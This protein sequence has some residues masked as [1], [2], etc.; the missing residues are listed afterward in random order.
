MYKSEL[1]T[2][3]TLCTSGRPLP[4][5]AHIHTGVRSSTCRRLR[6]LASVIYFTCSMLANSG[7][8]NPSPQIQFTY[9]HLVDIR[10]NKSLQL[11]ISTSSCG[12][13]VAAS[14]NMHKQGGPNL[15]SCFIS[16]CTGKVGQAFHTSKSC[17]TFCIPTAV[18]TCLSFSFCT[19][20]AGQTQPIEHACVVALLCCCVV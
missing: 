8:P 7:S 13:R 10:S 5:H 18:H 11:Q 20:K 1:L 2:C 15:S 9:I 6:G 4:P 19:G 16:I 12:A 14:F 3:N 17:N